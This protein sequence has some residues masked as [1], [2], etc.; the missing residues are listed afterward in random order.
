MK[1][2]IGHG[3]D[4]FEKFEYGK[5]TNSDPKTTSGDGDGTVN[6]KSLEYPLEWIKE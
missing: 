6:Y 2:V 4:T 1:V 5:D 3:V